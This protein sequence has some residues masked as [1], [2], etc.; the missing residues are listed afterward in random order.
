MYFDFNFFAVDIALP[1]YSAFVASYIYAVSATIV[2]NGRDIW[3]L[4][5]YFTASVYYICSLPQR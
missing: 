1:G 2:T 4:L 5:Q 3:N